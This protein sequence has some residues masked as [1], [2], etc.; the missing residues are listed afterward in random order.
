MSDCKVGRCQILYCSMMSSARL[1][2]LLPREHCRNFLFELCRALAFKKEGAAFHALREQIKKC[3]N[4]KAERTTIASLQE[5]LWRS[6]VKQGK[7]CWVI[8][9]RVG[10]L[11]ESQMLLCADCN[12]QCA[13]AGLAVLLQ[14]GRQWSCR[15]LC[16]RSEELALPVANTCSKVERV[17]QKLGIVTLHRQDSTQ[18]C[19]LAGGLQR[20]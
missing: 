7:D 6:Q 4:K 9:W 1:G 16:L 14:A 10:N 2:L 3:I 12:S 20:S 13:S 18:Q 5:K 15:C 19:R 17:S 8:T 11:L